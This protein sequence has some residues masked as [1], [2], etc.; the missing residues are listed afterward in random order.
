MGTGKRLV[1]QSPT[2][3]I[4]VG[5]LILL[6]KGPAFGRPWKLWGDIIRVLH[7][8]KGAYLE[9][10]AMVFILRQVRLCVCNSCS[11]SAAKY[12]SFAMWARVSPRQMLGHR[13]KERT[14]AN[15]ESFAAFA[16]LLAIVTCRSEATDI[17]IVE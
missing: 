11:R 16:S 17:Q 6:M 7:V 9:Y 10:L 8:E 4:L 13:G 2:K 14:A 15:F 5:L 12:L 3:S 1:R